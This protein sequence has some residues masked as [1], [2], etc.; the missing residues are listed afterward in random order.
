MG[1]GIKR[2]GQHRYRAYALPRFCTSPSRKG[3][4]SHAAGI[5][6]IGSGS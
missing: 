3:S 2:G 4:L 6:R 5:G 1:K